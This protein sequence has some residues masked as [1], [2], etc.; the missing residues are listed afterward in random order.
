MDESSISNKT[1]ADLSE[2]ELSE[3]YNLLKKQYDELT[4][5]YEAINQEVHETKRTYQT[6][7]EMQSFLQA[8]LEACKLEEQK[9]RQEIL[10]QISTLQEEITMLQNQGSEICDRNTAEITRLKNENRRLKEEKAIVCRTTPER[11]TKE[12][13]EIQRQLSSVTHEAASVKAEIEAARLEIESWRMRFEELVTEINELRAAA[14]MRR[15]EIKSI[16]DNEAVALAELAEIKAMLHQVD[17]G[18]QP[19]AKGNSIFA[20]VDDKRQEIA[21]NILQMK[22]SNT[23]LRQEIASRQSEI[24][25]LLHEK[26]TIWEEQAGANS[27]YDR[28]L[29]NSYEDRITQLEALCERHRRELCHWFAKPAD[30]TTPG[31][32]PELINHWKS[33]CELLRGELMAQTPARIS[34]TGL[35]KELRR[36]VALLTSTQK[37]SPQNDNDKSEVSIYR[38]PAKEIKKSDVKK[39][40]AFT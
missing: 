39:K 8:D 27:H 31:W 34:S 4:S 13:D 18:E 5:N 40:V 25:T 28:E 37:Q 26:Q 11:D 22:Q 35:I 30:P 6:S 16:N 12:V 24:E 20:E 33:E 32:L 38:V 9:Q 15:E 7:L 10:S 19:L 29:I 36:K 21:K 14:D 23:K 17:S 3:R 2:D 1:E